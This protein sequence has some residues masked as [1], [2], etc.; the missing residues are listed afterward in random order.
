[1]ARIFGKFDFTLYE[2]GEKD[3]AICHDFFVGMPRLD[4]KGVRVEIHARAAE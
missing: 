3:V 4:S 2:T 1:V